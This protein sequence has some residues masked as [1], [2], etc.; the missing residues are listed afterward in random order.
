MKQR[1]SY[2]LLMNLMNENPLGNINQRI[3]I[4]YLS[5]EKVYFWKIQAIMIVENVRWRKCFYGL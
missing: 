3:F 2:K 5:E 1:T 4:A